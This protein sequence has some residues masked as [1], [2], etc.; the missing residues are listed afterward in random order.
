MGGFLPPPAQA[1]G[2]GGGIPNATL[3]WVSAAP[4]NPPPFTVLAGD[5]KITGA[6]FTYRQGGEYVL[7]MSPLLTTGI[8]GLWITGL[9]HFNDAGGD[10][11]AVS[12]S[13]F[14]G[15]FVPGAKAIGLE[16]FRWNGAQFVSADRWF[17]LL[18]FAS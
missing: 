14:T 6:M 12:N 8:L 7:D 16:F 17:S 10:T 5:G 9:Q 2:G 15:D 4:Q 11:E 1:G 13:T 3:Y 18:I